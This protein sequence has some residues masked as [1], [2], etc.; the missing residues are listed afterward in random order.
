MTSMT[1]TGIGRVDPPLATDEVT[2]LR[3]FLDYHRDTCG[4]RPRA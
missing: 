4:G 3:A 1:S 2:M